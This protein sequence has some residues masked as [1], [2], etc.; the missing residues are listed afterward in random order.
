MEVS[1]TTASL[2]LLEHLLSDPA[3]APLFGQL[4]R[5]GQGVLTGIGPERVA[6]L[7]QELAR[8]FRTAFLLIAAFAG[9]GA[10]LAWTIP[11]RRL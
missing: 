10:F 3:A 6:F 8:A 11:I 5:E 1:G 7:Q 9:M 2:V 4:L